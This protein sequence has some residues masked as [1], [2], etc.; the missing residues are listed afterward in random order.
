MKTTVAPFLMFDGKAEEA[1]RFYVSLIPGSEVLGI[2][3]YGP[4][5]PGAEGSVMLGRFSL[6]GLAVLC[7]DSP[8]SHAFSFTP[9]T[10]LFVTCASDDE[11]ER[12]AAALAEDGEW[13]MPLDDHGFSRR[14]A[15]LNDRYGVSWQQNLE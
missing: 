6:A 11:I 2:Q 8:V 14:F 3:R 4:E 1:M 15:W 13:L 10:S 7:S 12:I 5:G 9:S